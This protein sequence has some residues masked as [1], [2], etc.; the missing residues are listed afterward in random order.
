MTTQQ[1]QPEA[2]AKELCTQHDRI[3]ELESKLAAV[4]QGVQDND[5]ECREKVAKA[6]GFDSLSS[7]A[8]SYLLKQIESLVGCEEELLELKRAARPTQQGLDARKDR[9]NIFFL[10]GWNGCN[11]GLDAHEQFKKATIAA[12]AKQGEQANG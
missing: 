9:D 4:Q 10:A 6:L 3:A 7:Y 2:A 1:Q 8:W 11:A 5:S 12:Q